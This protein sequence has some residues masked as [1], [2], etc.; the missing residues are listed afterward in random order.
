MPKK[1]EYGAQP[2]IELL[3]QF[4][5]HHGWYNRKDQQFIRIENIILL[6]ALGPP[7][8]GRNHI[9]PRI[10]RHFNIIAYTEIDNKTISN[11]FLMM[12]ESFLKRFSD[13]IKESIGV[14]VNSVIGIYDI[15]KKN[16]LPTPKKSHYTFNLRD[17]SKVFQGICSA[18][19]K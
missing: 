16:L 6:T 3:R 5:D 13:E 10:V 9:T 15:I 7:G 12:V 14:L 19:Q 11:I 1:E 8:G 2:P 18:S 4:L 17:I